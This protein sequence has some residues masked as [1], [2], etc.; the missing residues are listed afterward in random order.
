MTCRH[1]H[2][3]TKIDTSATFVN[4]HVISVFDGV[5][6]EGVLIL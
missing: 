6:G 2:N 4:Y 3:R 1:L 5:K